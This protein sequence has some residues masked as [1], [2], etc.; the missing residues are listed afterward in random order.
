MVVGD[1]SEGPA[2]PSTLVATRTT[3]IRRP[4]VSRA[5]AVAAAI[6]VAVAATACGAG[7]GSGP[8]TINL[9]YAPEENLHKVVDE[10]NA[11]AQG[12]YRIS[13]QVLPRGADDQRTQMVRRLAAQDDGM[14]VLGLDVTWTPEF[15]SAEWILEWTGEHLA[16]YVGS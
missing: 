2:G 11:Q 12:R 8:P 9:Y 6:A 13:Y 7:A 15:A 5:A 1:T 16:D 10:C 3:T 4:R 14:D